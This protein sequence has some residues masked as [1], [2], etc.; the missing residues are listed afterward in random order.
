MHDVARLAGVSVKTVSNV[1]NE[2]RHIRPETR[3]RVLAAIA[4]LDY[5]PNVTARGLRSGR[6]GVIGLAVPSL[7]EGY[8]AELADAVIAAAADRDLGVVIEQTGGERDRELAAVGGGARRLIDGLLFS[9]VAL[10]QR[11]ASLLDGTLPLVL[12][13]ERIFDGP[14]D[15]V[16]MHNV[17]SAQA[18]VEHLLA[19]GRRRIAVV[20]ASLDEPD[21]TGSAALRLVGYRR[22]LS[23]AGV[24]L[25]PALVRPAALWTL[26]Q[27]AAAT[28]LMLAQAIDAD[29]VFALNDSLGLGVLRALAEAG[30]RVPDTVSV[31]GFDDI[32]AGRYSFPSLSSVDPGRQ[33]IAELAVD[34]L[35]DRI[36]EK[37][38]RRPPR[39][40]KAAFRIVD[41]EST[42]G[43]DANVKGLSGETLRG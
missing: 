16:T 10:D 23:A 40:I 22:A 30:I 43:S 3:S 9:P 37:G 2:Y 24:A 27:G 8:F 21:A 4:E 36:R 38:E 25:D 32:D 42:I 39:T 11:D 31:L 13:G 7:R 41:R 18:A 1:V 17:S 29:A 28:R 5:R 34:L 19:L 12:L 6:T 26:E 15:H 20:G 35:V 33:Q 14:T